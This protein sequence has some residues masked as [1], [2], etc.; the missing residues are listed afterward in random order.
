M[1]HAKTVKR[2]A[3]ER[4][5]AARWAAAR[6]YLSLHKPEESRRFYARAA[7]FLL[8]ERHW[9]A[10]LREHQNGEHKN[11]RGM[12]IEFND[13]TSKR[14]KRPRGEDAE[15]EWRTV[16]G[17]IRKGDLRHRRVHLRRYTGEMMRII[18]ELHPVSR[19]GY[20]DRITGM[21]TFHSEVAA[22]YL[23]PTTAPQ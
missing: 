6:N 21:K 11:I 4:K 3:S 15:M 12:L 22:A 18:R 23:M 13:Q 2:A 17:R 19:D 16:S 14:M 10:K 5:K 8:P 1:G 7:K 9:N 20:R